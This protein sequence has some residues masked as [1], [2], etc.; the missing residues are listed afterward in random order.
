M[1]IHCLGASHPAAIH[2]AELLNLDNNNKVYF[3]SRSLSKHPDHQSLASFSANISEEDSV[4]SFLPIRVLAEFLSRHNIYSLRFHSLIALS[5]TSVFSK[6]YSK[7]TDSVSY[8]DFVIG[9][10]MI[11]SELSSMSI[12]PFKLVILRPTMLWGCHYDKNISFINSLLKR[13]RFF[14]VNSNASGLRRPLHYHQLSFIL[15]SLLV[16]RHTLPDSIVLANIQGPTTISFSQ[17]VDLVRSTVPGTTFRLIIPHFFLKFFA[18][19]LPPSSFLGSTLAMLCRQS[20]NLIY[21]DDSFLESLVS[22]YPHR[23][24][25]FSLF[26]SEFFAFK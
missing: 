19:C 20:E 11:M 23:Y 3:Y 12:D 7:S 18:T 21:D 4:I 9:E 14:P 25:F 5:S 24:S 16:N 13:F 22:S 6:V 26:Y 15:M 1:A 17:L 8:L 2:L 10:H